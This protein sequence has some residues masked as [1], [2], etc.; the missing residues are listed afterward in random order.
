MAVCSRVWSTS[1]SNGGK[2]HTEFVQDKGRQDES[3]LNLGPPADVIPEISLW[4]P[5]A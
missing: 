3:K 5:Y 1:R 2:I 4:N